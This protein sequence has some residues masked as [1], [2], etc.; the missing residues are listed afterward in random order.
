MTYFKDVFYLVIYLLLEI[1]LIM[2]NKTGGLSSRELMSSMG[3]A[4]FSVCC[5]IY[6]IVTQ[7]EKVWGEQSF[8]D[9]LMEVGPFRGRKGLPIIMPQI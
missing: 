7:R 8:E 2:G 4:G 1:G 5:V 9:I 3:L 6:F